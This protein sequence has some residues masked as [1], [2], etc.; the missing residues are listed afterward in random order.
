MLTILES[1][2]KKF[3]DKPFEDTNIIPWSTPVISFGN[4]RESQIATLGINPSNRE[5][6]DLDGKELIN[7]ERRFHTLG[8]LGIT[9]WTDVR[10]K[11][12]EQINNYCEDYFIRNPYDGW[13]K[14]LD[15]LISGTSKSYY[16]PSQEACHL[17]LVPWAT[18]S[19]WSE[20]KLRQ[21]KILLDTS[22]DFLG[23]IIKKSKI[24]VIVLNG[25]TVVSNFEKVSEIRFEKSEMN[26]W[27]LKRKT[28]IDVKGYGYKGFIENIGGIYLNKKILVLGYNHNIQS[29]FG[30]TNKVQNS[31]RNW[32]SDNLKEIL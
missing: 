22:I 31:I 21:Q 20:L 30:V 25:Q 19:K 24:K 27:A 5:F 8:S 11:H 14:R 10:S 3:L 6:V 18:S 32:I 26:D 29:S 7:I 1:I 12:L 17:D 4:I 15:Y 2:F 13:F 23:S 9:N 16:F 28:S